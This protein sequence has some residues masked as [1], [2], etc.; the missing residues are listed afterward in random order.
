MVIDKYEI[1]AKNTVSF[2]N[3]K[4][5]HLVLFAFQ[6]SHT[7]AALDFVYPQHNSL[8]GKVENDVEVFTSNAR[9][10]CTLDP[11]RLADTG[12]LAC[13]AAEEILKVSSYSFNGYIFVGLI[14][15]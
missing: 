11:A 8:Q 10:L 12:E 1:A 14:V 5:T 6:K 13:R 4:E 7:M 3:S 2:Q 15:F 9:A